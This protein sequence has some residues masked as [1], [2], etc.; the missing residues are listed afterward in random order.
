MFKATET[1][2][3][4]ACGFNF[5]TDVLALL[6]IY[7]KGFRDFLSLKDIKTNGN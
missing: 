3:L 2:F 5:W 4:L 1:S 7:Y 6:K